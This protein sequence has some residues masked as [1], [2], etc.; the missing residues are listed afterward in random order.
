MTQHVIKIFPLF[1]F[2][3]WKYGNKINILTDTQLDVLQSPVLCAQVLLRESEICR[4]NF[5]ESIEGSALRITFQFA[6][7]SAVQVSS[8]SLWLSLF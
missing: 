3:H 6:Y 2:L 5:P 8:G 4:K 7:L 1:F